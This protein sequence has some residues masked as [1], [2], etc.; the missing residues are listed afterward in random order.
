MNTRIM[1]RDYNERKILVWPLLVIK[2]IIEMLVN[3]MAPSA[4]SK[5]FELIVRLI[6][7]TIT[8]KELPNIDFVRKL[9]GLVRIISQ[10]VTAYELAKNP[11]WL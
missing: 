11:K 3:G 2:I 9:R 5:N 8:I 10:T 1:K 6:T 4:V 7:P